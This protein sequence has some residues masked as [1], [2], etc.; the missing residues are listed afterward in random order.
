MGDEKLLA[1]TIAGYAEDLNQRG[2]KRKSAIGLHF[3][4]FPLYLVLNIRLSIQRCISLHPLR[5]GAMGNMHVNQSS[6]PKVQWCRYLAVLHILLPHVEM[7]NPIYVRA[8][9]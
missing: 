9:L 5:M 3:C 2:T 1:E 7:L 4:F 8:L 6:H